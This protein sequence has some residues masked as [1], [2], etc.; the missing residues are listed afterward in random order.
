MPP[1]DD[2]DSEEEHDL[3]QE[4]EE[5]LADR[6]S[7]RVKVDAKFLGPG[8]GAGKKARKGGSIAWSDCRLQQRVAGY[9]AVFKG[10][11]TTHMCMH[12]LGD[13][14][15]CNTEL[16]LSKFK[17]SWSEVFIIK[18]SVPVFTEDLIDEIGAMFIN[19]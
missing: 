17:Q 16:T 9:E 3:D 14:K 11:K 12:S 8:K 7:Q 4:E 15:S 1:L 18:K 19:E 2:S 13:G 5:E 10:A 6:T